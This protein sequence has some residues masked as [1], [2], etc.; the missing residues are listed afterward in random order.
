MKIVNIVAMSGAVVLMS[1]SAALAKH[2]GNVCVPIA[3]DAAKVD[4]NQ[5]GV[6]NTSTTSTA[7]VICP[8][9]KKDTT[10]VGN[11]L[12]VV[13]YSR[14]PGP[15][16]MLNCQYLPL[17]FD[18]NLVAGP[19]SGVT[20]S[21]VGAQGSGAQQMKWIGPVLTN[22]MMFICVIPPMLNGQTSHITEIHYSN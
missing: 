20:K 6:H 4:R 17:N 11:V 5:F 7:T 10:D 19:G 18:G 21:I 3:A 2:N 13:A 8:I 12:T 22:N 9:D 1:G 16:G 14:N 15:P